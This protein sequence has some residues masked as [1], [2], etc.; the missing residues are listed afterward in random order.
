MTRPSKVPVGILISGRGSNMAA[1]A[2]AAAAPDFPA[3]IRCVIANR[4]DAQGLDFARRS[5]IR[6]EAIDNRA[7]PSRATFEEELDARLRSHGAEIVCLAGFMRVL[8]AAF[9][10][11]WPDRLL[12]IHPSLLPAFPGLDTHARALAEGCKVHG[13]TVHFVVPEVDAG[14]IIAQASVN[15][16]DTDDEC[17]LAARVLAQEHRIYPAALADLASGRLRIEGK[18]VLRTEGR[19]DG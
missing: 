9:V 4:E 6:A 10:A 2:A 13:C 18:R 5:G 16:L 8:S 11:R 1:L 7:F 12:N 17:A 3:E 15:V 14:P 19:K